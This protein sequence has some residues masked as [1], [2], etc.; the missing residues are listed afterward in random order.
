MKTPEVCEIDSR[1]KLVRDRVDS[2]GRPVLNGIDYIEVSHDQLSLHVYFLGKAPK[3][4]SKKNFV[5]TGGQRI[6]DIRVMDIDVCRMAGKDLD[7]CLRVS[8][9]KPGDFSNYTL[10]VVELDSHGLPTN[11]PLRGFD[12]RF[13]QID[14]S[15]KAGCPSDLDCLPR[16]ACLAQPFPPTDINYLAKDYSS[17]RQAILDRLALT[18]PEWQERHVPDIGIALVEVFAYVADH[19]SYY[20]DAVATEAYIDT[21]RQRISVRRHARLVDYLMHE[22][23]NAR[24]WVFVETVGG[25]V[26][27]K[28][29]EVAFIA[30]LKNAATDSAGMLNRDAL[31]RLNPQLSQYEVFEPLWP[32]QFTLTESHNEIQFYTWGDFE[33]CLPEGA[34]SATLVDEYLPEPPP[35]PP[36]PGAYQPPPYPPPKPA[37]RPPEHR[38][39]LNLHRGDVLIFEEVINPKTGKAGDADLTH[40]QA[41]ML[42]RVQQDEDDLT[43][44]PLVSIEWAAEDALPFALCISATGSAPDCERLENVSVARCNVLLVDHGRTIGARVVDDRGEEDLGLVPSEETVAECENVSCTPEVAIMPGSYRPSLQEEPLTFSEWLPDMESAVVEI[45]NEI[46]GNSCPKKEISA[47]SLLRQ[48]PRLA[49]PEINLMSRLPGDQVDLGWQPRYDLFA[50]LIDD[51]NY[52]V[53]ID[54]RGRA[55]LRFSQ[56]EMGRAPVA[57]EHFRARYR[58]GNG[59]AGNIGAES[60]SHIVLKNRLSGIQLQ[61]RNPLSASGGTEPESTERVKLFA[62]YAFRSELQRAITADDYAALAE[63]HPRVQRA[64]AVLH[65]TGAW[66]EV[67]VAID[68]KEQTEAPQLLLDEIECLLRPF[69]RIGHVVRVTAA[70]YV[71][72]DI[73]LSV[74]VKPDYLAAHVKADLL[75]LF[76]TRVLPDGRLGFF[77]PDNLTFGTGVM[78]SKV[79]AVAQS[80]TG[81]ENVM[82]TR[83]QRYRE[84]AGRELA[85]GILPI[86]SLEIARLD[87]DLSS[88]ENGKIEFQMMGGR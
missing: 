62:P 10:R 25:S 38:R 14:F 37:G 66:Y 67:N 34:T 58:I 3:P 78:V 65:W 71:P 46:G 17:F 76:S 52:V 83:L 1:R 29:N 4:I 51:L 86:G 26:V 5:I 33:C 88:P 31:R 64:R 59:V 60:I 36:K 28:K 15:F 42:T 57:G 30:G 20:Q 61:P 13:A 8:V 84:V 50:S 75:D 32:T 43:G 35:P 53:E 9:N 77:H 7:D 70:T 16:S 24:T 54:N 11:R 2:Q 12:R 45:P 49:L 85:D 23:C 41:V 73:E 27:L 39:K 47:A 82:V 74:C 40:R 81:V 56:G 21:A 6:T 44:Q 63:R 72:L 87:N 69:R 19:L 68:P 79:V 22:G 48:N 55:H 80:V 18:M